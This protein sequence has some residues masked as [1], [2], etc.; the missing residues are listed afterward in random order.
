MM[1]RSFD[2]PDWEPRFAAF[3]MDQSPADAAHGMDHVRRV[4]AAAKRIG[5]PERARP[6]IVV[7]AAWLH[8]CVHVEKNAADRASASRRAAEKATA[9]L[10]EA[11]YPVAHLEAIGHAIE[12]HSFSAGIAPQTLEA[13]VVQD[14][15]RLDALGA[16]GLA[17]CL[18]TGQHLGLPLYDPDDPFCRRRPPDDGRFVIDHL[19]VKLFRL[20][21]TMQT[22]AGR[23][24][25]RRRVQFLKRFLEELEAELL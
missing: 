9:F 11:G 19:Y 14:A 8:D 5:A 22:G 12:A 7:P 15:D 18:M 20:P 3:L 2:L 4:V 1:P 24:E 6:E 16:I 23:L 25:A 13:R 17:R 10:R 21:E